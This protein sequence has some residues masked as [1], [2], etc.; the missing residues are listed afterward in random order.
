MVYTSDMNVPSAR[1]C[2]RCAGT[3]HIVAERYGF[4]KYV[5]DTCEM[6]VGFDIT[7]REF[8]CFRGLPWLYTEGIYGRYLTKDEQRINVGEEAFQ[9]E[10][11]GQEVH[12]VQTESVH[13]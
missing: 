3:Q 5:C 13:L 4:G 1:D 2:T 8:M 9:E 7:D 11:S 6:A 10:G 12:D